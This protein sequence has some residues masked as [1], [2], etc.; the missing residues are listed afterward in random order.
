MVKPI[1]DQD[2]D[3]VFWTPNYQGLRLR[4]IKTLNG[5][6]EK[7]SVIVALWIDRTYENIKGST[8]RTY[9]GISIVDFA[10]YLYLIKKILIKMHCIENIVIF[11]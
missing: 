11:R 1:L 3:L 4:H 9:L 2:R 8:N 6:K 10:K 7:I 5:C